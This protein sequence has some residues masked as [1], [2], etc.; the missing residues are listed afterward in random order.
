MLSNIV[1]ATVLEV[2]GAT[3]GSESVSIVTERGTLRMFH[4]EDCCESVN[5]EDITGDPADLV[6][7]VV[8]VCEERD[9]EP[10]PFKEGE[11]VPESFTWT[12]IEIRTSK[13]DVTF[14]WLG[15]SNGYYGESPAYGWTPAGSSEEERGW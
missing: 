1:G 2:R 13:G 8:V 5:V 3:I 15:T 14:R 11:Y 9:N 6:G 10:P 7:G 4:A 12:F